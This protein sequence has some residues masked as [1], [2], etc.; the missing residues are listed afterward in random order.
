MLKEA[1]REINGPLGQLMQNLAG[2]EGEIW[3][4]EFKLFLRKEPCWLSKDDWSL[5]TSSADITL[6]STVLM[7]KFIARNFFIETKDNKARLRIYK[8]DIS[9]RKWFLNEVE[10]PQPSR[11]I[12]SRILSVASSQSSDILLGLGGPK[13][14]ALKLQDIASLLRNQTQGEVGHLLTNGSDNV[15]YI[16]AKTDLILQVRVNFCH[17]VAYR[18]WTITAD[19]INKFTVCVEGSKI[20]SRKS[21]FVI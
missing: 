17:Q 8:I 1:L 20:F 5:P 13:K 21:D 3:L 10:S 12:S 7:G 18:G 15:F 14:A 4:T 2:N 6:P 19:I 16:W 9:F 11:I